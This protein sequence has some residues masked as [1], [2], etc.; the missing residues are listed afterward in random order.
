MKKLL[1]TP[2]GTFIKGFLSIVLAMWVGELSNGHDLFSMDIDM[3]K[4]LCVAG[5]IPNIHVLI[6]WFDPEYKN[7][8][9]EKIEPIL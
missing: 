1:A 9:K 6:N 3:V 4:K 2:L 8:G 5:I 7:Y